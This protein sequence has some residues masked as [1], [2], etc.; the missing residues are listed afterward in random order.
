MKAL[1]FVFV[2]MAVYGVA[3]GHYGGALIALCMIGLVFYADK[4]FKQ[5]DAAWAADPRNAPNPRCTLRDLDDAGVECS[6]PSD[7]A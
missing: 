7:R 6:S 3:I 2:V 1:G 4:V 5:Q